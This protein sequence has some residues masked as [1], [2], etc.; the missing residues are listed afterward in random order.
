M[1]INDYIPQHYINKYKYTHDFHM[2]GLSVRCVWNETCSKIGCFYD[3]SV[4]VDALLI[5][6]CSI[7]IHVASRNIKNLSFTGFDVWA[8]NLSVI[9]SDSERD[10]TSNSKVEKMR[11]MHKSLKVEIQ[12]R[13]FRK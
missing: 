6:I 9:Q 3:E 7:E 8:R 13:V 5:F 11:L 1:L 2:L 4:D 12:E 10:G